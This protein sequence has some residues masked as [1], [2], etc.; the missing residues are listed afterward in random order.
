MIEQ[1]HLL[2]AIKCATGGKVATYIS[3][4]ITTGPRF[5][6]WYIS[7][8]YLLE[9]DYKTYQQNK[10]ISVVN[11]NESDLFEAAKSLRNN[12]TGPV[13]EPASLHISCWKQNDYYLFW[14]ELMR[15]FVSRVIALDGW[16]YSIGCVIEFHHAIKCGIQ[17]ETVNGELLKEENA[18]KL[19]IDAA[20]NI[21]LRGASF[22]L[23]KQM[24]LKL[25][26]QELIYGETIA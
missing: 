25:K 16:Q 8:G 6:E 2:Q 21:E 14:T 12:F 22:E 10:Q 26:S 24:A 4:P 23:L 9:N 1:K 18:R 19:I 15:R 17:V 5:I 3:G 7:T 11:L 20:E 13:I